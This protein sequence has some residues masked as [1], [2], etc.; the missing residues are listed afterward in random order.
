MGHTLSRH[1]T[2][3]AGY[4]LVAQLHP[5]FSPLMLT[6]AIVKRGCRPANSKTARVEARFGSVVRSRLAQKKEEE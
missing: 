1:A 3:I 6:G 5:R 2:K 4:L